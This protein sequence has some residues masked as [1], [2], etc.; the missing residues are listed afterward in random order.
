MDLK[1]WG[2]LADFRVVDHEDGDALILVRGKR[3]PKISRREGPRRRNAEDSSSSSLLPPLCA[4]KNSHLRRERD[5]QEALPLPLLQL[6]CFWKVFRREEACRSK[7]RLKMR[8][9]SSSR[10]GPGALGGTGEAGEKAFLGR[11]P[12]LTERELDRKEEVDRRR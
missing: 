9:R 4:E 2:E 12:I 10:G 3:Y 6:W 7:R 8:E 5:P 1:G 11:I